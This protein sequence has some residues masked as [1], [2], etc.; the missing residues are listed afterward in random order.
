MSKS[1]QILGDIGFYSSSIVLT[2]VVTVVAAVMM[3]HFLGPTQVGVWSFIQI[4]LMYAEYSSL[5]TMNTIAFEI[6]F[7]NGKGQAQKA[8]RIKNTVFT[9]SLLSSLLFSAGLFLYALCRRQTLPPQLFYAFLFAAVL[10]LL[11]RINGLFI[12][13]LRAYKYF[14]LAGKQMFFSSIVNACLI[15]ILSAKFKLYGFMV[16]MVFSFAFNI[17]YILKNIR[18]YFKFSLDL[19]ELGSLI[20]YGFPLMI[21]ALLGTFYETIDRMMITKFLGFES[22]GLYSIALMASSYIF[23]IPNSIGIVVVPNMQERYGQSE[24]KHDLKGYIDKSNLVFSC[25]IPVLIGMGWFLVPYVVRT[26]LPKFID[27]IPALRWLVLGGY[28]LAAGQTYSQFIYTIR[29]H[30]VLIPFSILSCGLAALFIWLAIRRGYGIEGVAGAT[31]IA[32]ACHFTFLYIYVA[33]HI[34]SKG[35][36]IRHYLGLAAKF[37]YMIVALL[38]VKIFIMTPFLSLTTALQAGVYLLVYVPFLSEVNK[39]FGVFSMLREKM[40]G[41]SSAVKNG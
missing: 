14:T 35:E 34:Y 1:K 20:R 41:K 18:F 17:F 12:A 11:Q 28:F 19:R 9:F 40:T 39:K 5:G 16:A 33:S 25:L 29:R 7:Y 2:Q 24:D 37:F 31:V 8:E 27:G 10:V 26:L 21:V 38:S 13:L 6:P 36:A 4:V 23:S 3:R 32:I 22:L 15:G 30:F